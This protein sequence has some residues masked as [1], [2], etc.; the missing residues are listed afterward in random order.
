MTLD[1]YRQVLNALNDQIKTLE[2]ERKTFIEQHKEIIDKQIE[3][4][5]KEDRKWFLNNFDVFWAN[6]YKFHKDTSN[7]DIIIDFLFVYTYGQHCITDITVNDLITLWNL[8]FTYQG[9]PIIEYTYNRVVHHLF[10]I[11]N[12]KVEEA[13][14]LTPENLRF[15]PLLLGVLE[16]MSTHRRVFSICDEYKTIKVMREVLSN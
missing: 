6:R 2:I 9:Y 8:G 10:Y 12:G 13:R 15:S 3:K 5:K 7:G 14:G 1:Q 4:R 16:Y 11:R